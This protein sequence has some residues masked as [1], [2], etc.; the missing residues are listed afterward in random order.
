[1]GIIVF[2]AFH[3]RILWGSPFF[4]RFP[5]EDGWGAGLAGGAFGEVPIYWERQFRKNAIYGI[6]SAD[7]ESI[8]LV[9]VETNVQPE[10]CAEHLKG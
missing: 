10:A 2:L 8:V 6:M 5:R 1:M 3:I 9:C 7:K 4:R